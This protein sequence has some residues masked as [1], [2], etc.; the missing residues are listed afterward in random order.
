MALAPKNLRKLDLVARRPVA[1]HGIFTIE[2]ATY[3]GYP[4]DI[5]LLACRDWA[6]VIAETEDGDVVL[7]W[8]YR[9]G[10]D[11][12]SLEI[13]GGVVDAGEDPAAAAIREL[14]EETGYAADRVELLATWAPNPAFQGNRMHTFVARGVRLEGAAAFDDLEDLETLLVPRAEIAGLLDR[15]AIDHALIVCALER[16]LRRVTGPGTPSPA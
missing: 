1:D 5:T 10:T 4:R 13:P 8:Q 16:W 9:Y 2:H 11:R 15:G 12:F 3:A 6:N 14:R 7:V